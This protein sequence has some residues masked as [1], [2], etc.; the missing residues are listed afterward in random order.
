MIMNNRLIHS[1]I[2]LNKLNKLKRKRGE[3]NERRNRK[4]KNN[5]ELIDFFKH[6]DWS[7]LWLI[8]IGHLIDL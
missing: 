8:K 5:R 4:K 6:C 1:I 7:K 2:K 3:M